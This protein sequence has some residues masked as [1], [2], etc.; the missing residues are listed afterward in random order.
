MARKTKGTVSF[1][2]KPFSTRQKQV[3]TWWMPG[4][5]YDD[6]DGIICDGSIRSGK[7]ISMIK[8][9]VLW[10][11][12]TFSGED[13]ILAGRSMG[14]LKRNVLKPMF[15]ILK[16]LAIP[17]YYNRSDHYIEIGGNTYYCFGASTEASQDVVQG[18]TAAGAYAD[19]AAL[20]PKSFIEQMIGRCSVPGSKFWMNC[21]PKGPYHFI[22]EEYID[23]AEDKKILHLHFTLDDNDALD[24]RI[25]DRYKR[26]FSGVFYQR[27]VLGLWVMAEGIIY[28]MF[29]R[30]E[31]VVTKLPEIKRYWIGVD[32]GT[33]NATTFILCGLGI[34]NRAYIIDEYYHSGRAAKEDEVDKDPSKAMTRQKSP[35]A[36]S[37][38]FQ[39]WYKKNEERYF[40]DKEG[41][42]PDRYPEWIMVDPAAEGFILQLHEDGIRRVARA[43]NAVNRGIELISTIMEM[44]LFRVHKRCKWVIKELGS[45][46]WDEKAQERGEDKPL[47]QHDHTL[48]AIRYIF[49]GTRRIWARLGDVK[50]AAS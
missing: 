16:S 5:P 19:E 6:Y 8:S 41:R 36:Y 31:M 35:A 2:F 48:D 44:D 42:K 38:D 14:A 50:D 7:T 12:N 28:S 1:D 33:S 24:E 20:F 18:L 9:F 26:M 30:K 45:Y 25:K 34:D 27:Y 11:V 22:K 13:F 10:S 37:K 3:L 39:K 49:N 23:Q 4:S 15:R 21:N 47:K 46:V 29:D 17:Y 40:K 32:Y 43:D